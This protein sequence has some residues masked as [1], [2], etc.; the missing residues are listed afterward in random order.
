MSAPKDKLPL[1][2]MNR[3]NARPVVCTDPETGATKE[4]RS[5]NATV[6]DGFDKKSVRDCCEGRR[7]THRNLLWEF[8]R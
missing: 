7:R 5:L 6:E 4:Y 3:I 1:S 2:G 8:K